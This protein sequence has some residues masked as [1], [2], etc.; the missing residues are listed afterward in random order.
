VNAKL[1]ARFEA[2][3]ELLN[4]LGIDATEKNLFHGTAAT[5]I[6]PILQ[7]RVPF[8]KH[9]LMLTIRLHTRM[10]FSF[11]ESLEG[12]EKSMVRRVVSEY[13]LQRA[14]RPRW[15]IH[16]ALHGC[17]CVAVRSYP[18]YPQRS[19]H[20]AVITGRSTNLGEY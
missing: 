4:S 2:A 16:S 3:K 12:S 20:P 9:N 5:N 8:L 13:T 17:L 18:T 15:G 7:V 10:G 6:Q 1:E 19:L 11:P 14:P